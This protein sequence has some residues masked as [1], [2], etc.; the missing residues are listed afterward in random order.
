MERQMTLSEQEEQARRE[1]VM[2]ELRKIL[3]KHEAA[4]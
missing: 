3:A 4:V 2:V 1:A